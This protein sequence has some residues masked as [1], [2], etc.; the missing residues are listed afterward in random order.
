LAIPGKQRSA[1]RRIRFDE[2]NVQRLA[3]PRQ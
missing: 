1:E 3:R 2:Q